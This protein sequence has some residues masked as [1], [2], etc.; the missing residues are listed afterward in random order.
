MNIKMIKNKEMHLIKLD[1][2]GTSTNPDFSTLNENLNKVLQKLKKL[3]HK[4]CFTTGRNYLSALPFYNE[5]GLDTYLV[6]YNGAYIN[7]P[8]DQNNREAAVLNPIKNEIVKGI[9]NEP[10]IKKN[11]LNVLIDQVDLKTIST[12]ND[13]YYQ[14]IFFNSNP[15][16]QGE[17]ILQL[18]GEKDALQLVLE[19]PC[20]ELEAERTF[21][22]ILTTLH[23]KYGSS[24]TFYYGNKLKAKRAGEKI[25]VPDPKRKIIKIRSISAS[26]GEGAR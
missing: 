24:V 16:T 15:Y 18:L 10:L 23:N 12:S 21:N 2:D 14:E 13:T 22:K 19:L 7:N 5:V 17:D 8:S 11:L 3:G 6:T 25:L 26:K 9:L 1:I 4:I 20:F